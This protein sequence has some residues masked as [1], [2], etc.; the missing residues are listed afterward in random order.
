MKQSFPSEKLWCEIIFVE[1]NLF[2]GL[3][4]GHFKISA[5]LFRFYEENDKK[6][7]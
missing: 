7:L 2:I 1:Y 3:L 5:S 4:L 6:T